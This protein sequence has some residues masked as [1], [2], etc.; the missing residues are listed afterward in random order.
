MKDFID[1]WLPFAGYLCF[2]PAGK[3]IIQV[4]LTL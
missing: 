4:L 2:E 3:N 1:A